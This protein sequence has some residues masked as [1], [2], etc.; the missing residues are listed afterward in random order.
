MTGGTH[1]TVGSERRKMPLGEE[2]CVDYSVPN[3]RVMF[4]SLLV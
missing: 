2:V 1:V 4:P 3:R